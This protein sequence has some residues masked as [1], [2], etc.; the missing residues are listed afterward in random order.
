[1]S[2]ES[3]LSSGSENLP[4]AFNRPNASRI[5]RIRK[6]LMIPQGS[7]EKPTSGSYGRKEPR[8]GRE[9]RGRLVPPVRCAQLSQRGQSVRDLS[10]CRSLDL[11]KKID[12][13]RQ[14]IANN[15]GNRHGGRH[16][17]HRRHRPSFLGIGSH[18]TDSL[19]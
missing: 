3:D 15:I 9:C 5:C 8:S 17:V 4:R 10:F 12:V 16:P 7:H 13:S 19:S 1:M 14:Y 11:V 6:I 2:E 18:V